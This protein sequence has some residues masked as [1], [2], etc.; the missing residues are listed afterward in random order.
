MSETDS[1]LN[2]IIIATVCFI[3]SIV[4]FFMGI[5]FGIASWQSD[6]VPGFSI[7]WGLSLVLF[8]GG[9]V[10]LWKTRKKPNHKL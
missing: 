9:F 1:N 7:S 3:G 8:I 10:I 4:L 6:L 2:G 5:F